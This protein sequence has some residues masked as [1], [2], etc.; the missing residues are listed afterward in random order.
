MLFA[1]NGIPES[2]QCNNGTQFTSGEFHQLA[3]QYGFEIVMS[4]PLSFLF[5]EHQVQTVKED[6][7]LALLSLQTMPLS[8]NMPSLAEILNS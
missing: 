4:S 2:L 8:S 7:D 3:S 5:V 6:I 1:E